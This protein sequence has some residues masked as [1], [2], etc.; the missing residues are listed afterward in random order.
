MSSKSVSST[1]TKSK[2]YRSIP[3][4]VA[5]ITS[6]ND[7]LETHSITPKEALDILDSYDTII[8]NELISKQ[9]QKGKGRVPIAV[10]T[11]ELESYQILFNNW[12]WDVSNFKL[13]IG[14]KV[15]RLDNTRILFNTY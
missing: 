5:L 11:G 6:L 12:K 8:H 3:L 15:L 4:G 9:Y 1:T 10:A 2:Y 14:K 7:L 13:R